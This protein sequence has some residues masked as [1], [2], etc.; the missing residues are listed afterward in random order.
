MEYPKRVEQHISESISFKVLSSV[1]PDEWI[2]RELTERDYGVDLY[3]EIVGKD[4]KV[5]GNLVAL[6]VKSSKSIKFNKKGKCAFGAIKKTT[7]NYW[8]G[9]PVPVFLIVV[10]LDDRQ[11]YWSS[12]ENNNREGRFN[13]DSKTASLLLDIDHKFSNDALTLFMLTYLREK[14]WNEIEN[15]IEKSIMAYNTLGPLVLICKREDDN[16][17]CSST[18]QYMLIQHY[19]YF[20]VLYRYLLHEK[21]EYLPYWYNKHIEYLKGDGSPKSLT[22]SFK[23]IK[24][25]INYFIWKYHD[26]IIA[27]YQLVTDLQKDYFSRRFPYLYAHLSVRPLAFIMDDWSAR[28][29]FDEYENETQRPEKLFFQDFTEFDFMIDDL[30]KT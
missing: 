28:Y 17:Y 8:L 6:Q 12:V 7:I 15:A 9:L 19:E 1:L 27:G 16:K 18:I 4:K 29:F 2:V 22:F 25:I 20:T 11:V 3:I 26:C 14:R 23:L 24:E 10:S 30:S 13:N 5:T 21:P